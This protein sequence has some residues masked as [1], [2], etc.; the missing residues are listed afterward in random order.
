VA[1]NK[2]IY[3][4][5]IL[6]YTQIIAPYEAL[7]AQ[8]RNRAH[9]VTAKVTF[10]RN[11]LN[12]AKLYLVLV[13]HLHAWKTHSLSTRFVRT[14]GSQLLTSLEQVVIIL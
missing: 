5:V 8:I 2:E 3:Q 1:E 6:A 7:R 9:I 10:S 11:L 4:T 13:V 12:V 14:A